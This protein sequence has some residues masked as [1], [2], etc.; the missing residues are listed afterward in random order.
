MN[1]EPKKL[2]I[3]QANCLALGIQKMT[4][5]EKRLLLLVMALVRREDDDFKTY[6]LPVKQVAGYLNLKTKDLYDRIK[7]ITD[8]LLQRIVEIK[9][10]DGGWIKFQWVSHAEYVPGSVS[11]DGRAQLM[12]RL[13]PDL[14]PNLLKLTEHFGSM[15]F[16]Q[17]AN[18]KRYTS[19]RLFELLYFQAKRN[20]YELNFELDELKKMLGLESE[21]KQYTDFEKRVLIPAQ[22]ECAQSANLNFTYQ[23][24]RRGRQVVAIIF[25]V[26]KQAQ[27]VSAPPEVIEKLQ[28]SGFVGNADKL[29]E[30]YGEKAIV[31]SITLA[32]RRV[33]ESIST[34]NPI[35]NP[36]GLIVKI[37]ANGSYRIIEEER[38]QTKAKQEEAKQT[39]LSQDKASQQSANKMQVVD[40][41]WLELT[42]DQQVSVHDWIKQNT[43]KAILNVIKSSNWQGQMYKAERTRAMEVLGF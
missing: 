29:L 3:T 24:K 34:G 7:S 8:R 28:K 41:R 20:S 26:S 19:I 39:K 33:S 6:Q 23:A 43:V 1:I 2:I 21:Y 10:P 18:M 27:V 40:E 42:E 35:R 12:L 38:I 4:L 31:D 25:S 9:K 14:K 30:Q 16:C 32:K 5:H 17:I 11:A 13:H 37:L 22:Q 36:G 15:P